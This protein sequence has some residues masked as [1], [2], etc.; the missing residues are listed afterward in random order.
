VK[1]VFFDVGG[2]LIHPWP[3]VGE[4]YATVAARH[5]I[6][7]TPEQ[8]ERGF[9]A[10]WKALKHESNVAA[11]YER[12]RRKTGSESAVPDRRYSPP[13][14]PTTH[15][16]YELTVSRKDWWR[17]L[18]FRVFGQRNE[19]CFD[20]LFDCFAHAHAWKLYPDAI[21]TLREVRVNRM[22]V[23]VISNWD[24]RLRPL[25]H[26]LGIAPMLDSITVSCEVG[27]EKPHREIF[28]AALEAAGVRP[29]EA[30]H[31]GDSYEEDV[32]GAEVIGMGAVLLDRED[33][34]REK[35]ITNLRQM[36]L[37]QNNE[38]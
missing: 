21:D 18:V 23:G 2:T 10:S 16:K 22:H 7:I 8:A 24:E 30:S 36:R 9:R 31:V 26:E 32:R 19:A 28:H 33:R 35:S 1:A 13:P 3:S 29:D 15:A 11:P 27:A 34:E 20:E 17:E 25:L 5:G 4:I 38:I 37:L 6:T 12:R 14:V